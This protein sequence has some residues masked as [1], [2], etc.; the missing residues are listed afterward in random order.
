MGG[1]GV[2]R[3]FVTK[4]CWMLK[5]QQIHMVSI[6]PQSGEWDPDGDGKRE[7]EGTR[8]EERGE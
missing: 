5:Q 1:G 7:R 2:E 6:E 3:C 4:S 8:E